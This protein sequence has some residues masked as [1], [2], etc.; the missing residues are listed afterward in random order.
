MPNLFFAPAD[1]GGDPSSG[2]LITGAGDRTT[3]LRLGL[4]RSGGRRRIILTASASQNG[5]ALPHV[6]KPGSQD[7]EGPV[8]DRNASHH[9]GRS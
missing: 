9:Q 2:N 7:R 3:A 6:A 1:V 8:G 4:S 5:K